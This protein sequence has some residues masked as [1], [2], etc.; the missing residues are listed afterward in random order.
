MTSPGETD[1][2]A[3]LRDMSPELHDGAF[4]YSSVPGAVPP[5]ANPV[6]FVREEEGLTLILRRHEA[7]ELGLPYDYVAAW[8]TLQVPSSL[9]A[10]GLTAAVCGA[11]ADAGISANVVAGLR[12]DHLFVPFERGVDAVRTLRALSDSQSLGGTLAG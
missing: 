10:V 3:L 6:A 11:L 5:G 1:L 12:H 2:T 9:E 7:D 8:I 4:V